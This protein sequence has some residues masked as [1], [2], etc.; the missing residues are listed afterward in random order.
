MQSQSFFFVDRVLKP[1]GGGSSDIFG[2]SGDTAEPQRKTKTN[3]LTSSLSF[4]GEEFVT[5]SRNRAGN[6]SF[7]NLFGTEPHHRPES[8]VKD[9]LISTINCDQS[10]KDLEEN[11]VKKSLHFND[12][13][14][15]ENT[16]SVTNGV[17]PSPVDPCETNG[18]ADKNGSLRD[19]NEG[20]N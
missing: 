15:T 16:V 1:P 6:D 20:K 7:Y 2:A 14:S 4:G 13:D 17:A 19:D 12:I 8:A 3:H 9:K 18:S 10:T 5:P 11:I